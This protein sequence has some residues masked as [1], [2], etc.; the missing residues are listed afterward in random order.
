MPIT[1]GAAGEIARRARGTPRL[2]NRLLRRIRDFAEVGGDGSV[3]EE[4]VDFAM[5]RLGIDRDGIDAID[6]RIMETLVFKFRGRPVGLETIAAAI[7]E[8]PENIEE[9]Y[10]PFLLQKGLVDKTP[11]GRMATP[12]TY[13]YLDVPLP[14]QM[15]FFSS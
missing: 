2:A 3:T 7:S 13:E 4:I 5:E 10:E 1:S 6:R 8:E 9:V 14:E 12:L 15:T 11:R